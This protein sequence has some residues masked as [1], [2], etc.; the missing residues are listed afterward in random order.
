[1]E[2]TCFA[3]CATPPRGFHRRLRL[4]DRQPGRFEK[5]PAGGGEFDAPGA[6]LKK[7]RA[8]FLFQIANLSAQG[9]LRR[10]KDSFRR[11]LEA[12]RFGDRDEVAKMPQLHRSTY[13]SGAYAS[14]HK[15]FS[16]SV[17]NA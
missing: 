8:D 2:N 13:I 9:R 16:T 14:A 5:C 11:D 15:V 6:A 10:V 4:C 12:S 17:V 1:M 7:L 3:G